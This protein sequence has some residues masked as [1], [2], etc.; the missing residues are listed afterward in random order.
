MTPRLRRPRLLRGGT[1]ALLLAG[2]VTGLLAGPSAG[3]AAAEPGGL[4][5]AHRPAATT[6]PPPLPVPLAASVDT[7]GEAWA[8]VPMGDLNTLVNTF[9]Q[10]FVQTPASGKWALA[11]PPGVADN[12]GLVA[13]VEAGDGGGSGGDLVSV[14]F[15]PSQGLEFSPLAQTSNGGGADDT[16]WSPALAPGALAAVPDALTTSSP[17]GPGDPGTALALVRAHGGQVWA[18]TTGLA[19]WSLLTRAAALSAAVRNSCDVTGLDAVAS[20]P[21]GVPLVAAGCGHGGQV[22]IFAQ[23]GRGHWQLAGP[24]LIGDLSDASTQVLRLTTSGS[25]TT[26][27]V[28]SAHDGRRALIAFWQP[29]AGGPWMASLPYHLAPATSL[30]STAVGSDGTLAVLLRQAD[31]ARA[32]VEVAGGGRSWYES[33]VPPASARTVAVLPG[34]QLEAFGVSGSRLTVYAFNAAL[35]SWTVAQTTTVPIAYGSSS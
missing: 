3:P 7:P 27:L 19:G 15:E 21:G 18:G 12:G 10:L 16:D 8:V 6:P 25:Q 28:A 31:G 26:A 32:L 24:S 1:G 2:L 4:R 11:T 29:V 13:S 17:G 20:G 9:W 22:G 5:S 30:V 14:G 34:G 35:S 23:T 33:A